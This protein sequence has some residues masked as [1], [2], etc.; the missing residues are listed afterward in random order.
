MMTDPNTD[1]LLAN[2]YQLLGLVGKG[3]MGRVYQA[4]DMLLGGVTVAVKFLSQTLLN[5][6][7]RDRF[8]REATICAVLGEKSIHI[9]R[10]RDYG[11]DEN[12]IPFYVMEFLQGES[13]SEV[14]KDRPLSLPRFLNITRQIC[15]GLQCAHQGILIDGEV[16][17]IIHRDIKPS[18]ITVVQDTTLGELVKILDF[19]IAK[20]LQSDIAQTNSFMGTLAYCSPEQMEGR[21]LDKRSDIYSLGVMMFEMLTAEMP[22]MAETHSFGGWY[23]AHHFIPPRTFDSV[24]PDLKL[25]KS[26]ESLVMSCLAKVPSDR[27]QNAAQVLQALEPL[28]QRFGQGRQLGQRIGEVLSK[29]PVV[30]DPKPKNAPTADE[31][32]RL[33]S[34][35]KNKPIAEIVFPHL[36]R[37][38]REVLPTLWVMLHKPE[39]QNRLI[40]TR[41]NQFLFL[42]SPHPMLLWITALH[43]REQGPRWLSCYLDLK[44]SMGQDIVRQL[45]ENGIYRILFFALEEPH[46]CAN[47]MISTIAPVQRQMLQE[48][49]NTS[50]TLPSV[51]QPQMSKSLLKQEFEKLKP[52]ILMKLESVQTGDYSSDISG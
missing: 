37:T 11:V 41:Y 29:L 4:R 24:N 14:L 23:K 40:S 31:V 52:K 34:W 45:G 17:P 51:A 27:P 48:W 44:T 43:N 10:V 25:P 5:Q 19:G 21:E 46:R 6:K 2:R 22:L 13:L 1:R 15:L 16:C 26:L 36:L 39:I 42:M 30:A 20:L 28:E 8:E 38:S 12:E 49:A 3:A 32:C 9:V 18:N 50:Q 35:P 33:T 7:M 47:V